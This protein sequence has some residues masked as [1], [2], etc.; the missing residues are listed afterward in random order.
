VRVLEAYV[1]R[2]LPEPPVA[3]V[4]SSLPPASLD[5]T[6][7]ARVCALS[8]PDLDSVQLSHVRKVTPFETNDGR[9][10]VSHPSTSPTSFLH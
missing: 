2:E 6:L 8:S 5:V 4:T 7:T 10:W 9:G 1:Q 3:G